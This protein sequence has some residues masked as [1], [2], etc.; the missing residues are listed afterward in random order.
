MN[1]FDRTA[2]TDHE[3]G[4]TAG[5]II[6][7]VRRIAFAY[8]DRVASA[9]TEIGVH[10]TDLRAL[11]L[12][13]DS[14][15]S[16]REVVTVGNLGAALHMNQPSVTAVVDRLVDHALVERIPVPG[17]RRKVGLAVTVEGEQAGWAAFG[18]LIEELHD[19]LSRTSARR[20]ADSERVLQLTLDVLSADTGA[21]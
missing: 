11:A 14:K 12:I 20:L 16:G 3:P 15:R 1:N 21:S 17:D 7:L 10:P 18:S 6:H 4:D 19:H 5:R 9:A 8:S 2:W 13:L